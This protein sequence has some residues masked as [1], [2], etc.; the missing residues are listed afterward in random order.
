MTATAP[1]TTT[2][3]TLVPR[4]IRDARWHGVAP[5]V[6]QGGMGVA[7]SGWPL[8]RAVASVGQLGV[9]SGTALDV[10]CARRL[11]D[12]DT[13]GHVRRALAAFPVPGVAE[14]IL[15]AYFVEGGIAPGVAYRPVPRHT[16]ASGEKLLQL[17]VAA[18]F[19]EVFLA[20]EGHEG[21]VGVNYLH[22]IDLPLPAACFGALLAGVDVVLVGAGNPADIPAL[23]RGLA[24]GEDVRLAI[25]VMGNRVDDGPTEVLFSPRSV[26]PGVAEL[27]VPLVLAIIASN[28]LASGLVGDPA[29]SPDGFVVEGA[30]AGGHNAPP[31]GPRAL[32]GLGQPVYGERDEVDIAAVVA[33]GLPV[34]VAG[35]Q[36]TPD[37]LRTALASGAT[38]IQA[39]TVFAYSD[40]SGFPDDVK[41]HVREGAL[42]GELLVRADWRVSPTG[43]PFRVAELPRTLTDPEVAAARQPVCDLGVLRSAYRRPDGAVDF[44][45]PAEPQKAYLRK[46]GRE[47]NREGRVCL[48][49][50]LLAGAGM[51]QRRPRGAVE[52]ALVTAGGDLAPVVTMLRRR[53][54]G[55]SGYTA[56]EVVT[57][58]LTGAEPEACTG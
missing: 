12:G 1:T 28:D 45:C 20:K 13:G 50:A 32:D 54:A 53:R 33:L 22:K 36:G 27:P 5:R 10:V 14:W 4:V 39:G 3:P 48:C 21:L 55:T 2:A 6:I 31:R 38:G 49:N 30:S 19:V 29:T 44:R 15:A 17:T 7:I 51:P 46:G 40:E 9:V 47:A 35:G 18:N 57:H 25:K 24:T 37:G 42:S 16:V 8:A 26:V 52:P 11:Q 23:V 58:L 41:A 56:A 34:W 43:F